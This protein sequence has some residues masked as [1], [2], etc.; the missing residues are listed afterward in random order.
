M[1]RC[2]WAVTEMMQE[3]HDKEWGNFTVDDYV[4]FEHICLEGFQSGLSWG[5]ILRKRNALRK[6]FKD[7]K[8]ENLIDIPQTKIKKI[9]ENEQGI[10]NKMKIDSVFNNARCFVKIQEKYG[11]FGKHIFEFLGEKIITGNYET[12]KQLPSYTESSTKL[13]KYLKKQGF[14]YVGPTTIYAHMQAVGFVND[15]INSCFKK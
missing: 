5:I 4:H 6:L 15:H 10:R 7:F 11:S 1:N 2:D 12:C 3:Y 13:S 14:T 8:P 9:Y